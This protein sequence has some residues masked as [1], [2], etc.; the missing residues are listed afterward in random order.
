MEKLLR[1]YLNTIY[2]KTR[3]G[4]QTEGSYYGA[5]ED[6]FTDYP[7]EKGRK[8]KVT[9]LPKKTEAGN[10]DFRVWDGD[11]FIVGYIEAKTPGTNLDQVETSE[12][13]QRYIHTF[14]N[15][16]LTDFYEFRLYRDG[17]HIDSATIARYH[18]AKAL[19]T[20]PTLQNID[21]FERLANAFFS[22]KLPKSF[23]A[24]SLATQLAKRTRFLRDIVF[25]QLEEEIPI[26]KGDL[27]NYY[28]AFKRYL[29]TSLTPQSFAD[30]YA[31][32]ITY[33]MFA[34]RTRNQH[35]FTRK[36]AVEYV[37]HTTGILS[38][39]FEY[40]SYAKS[41]EQITVTIDDIAAVLN[42]ADINSILDQYYKQGKG[43]DPIMHFYETFLNQY[44]PSMREKRGV[45]YT[46]ESV[47][48]Y[49]V[50]SVHEILKTDFNMPDGLANKDVTL[51]D[52]AAGTLT[53][54]AEAIKLAVETYVNKYGEGGKDN[55]IRRQILPNFFAFELMMAPYAIGHMKVAYLLES[56]GFQM[57]GDDAFKLYLTNTLE[58]DEIE[59][60]PL[61]FVASLSE[62]S[63]KAGEVKREPVLVIL[64]NPPYSGTSANVNDW[65]EE[66]L[67]T[68]I[69]GAQSYYKV[70]GNPLGERN[71]KMLQDDYVKFLRFA[72]WKIQKAGKG[73][74]AMI[75]N[76]AWLENPTFRG[77]RQSMMNTF[78]KIYIL[79]LHGNSLKKETA[80][81]GSK[82]ENVFDIRVGVAI[83]LLV[84]TPNSEKADRTVQHSDLYGSRETKYELLNVNDLTSTNWKQL[85]PGSGFYL[86]SPRDETKY[87]EYK[88]FV[89]VTDIFP[90]NSTGIKTHRDAFVIDSDKNALERRISQFRDL[91]LSDEI[92]RKAFNL[93][94]TRDWSMS[95]A[96]KQLAENQNWKNH[97]SSITY[98]PFDN[99]FIYNSSEL[100]EWPRKE[101]MQHMSEENLMLITVRQVAE[102][103]FSHAFISDILVES[104]ITTSNRGMAYVFPLYLY[105]DEENHEG[106]L[107]MEGIDG[108]VLEKTANIDQM[109]MKKLED[110][111]GK[112]VSPE[113]VL[114]YIY[115]VLYSPSYRSVYA[116]FLKFDYPRIPFTSDYALFR[117]MAE[118]G[119]RLKDLHLMTSDEINEPVVR[120]QGQGEDIVK[121]RRYNEDEKRLYINE[122]KYFEHLEPEVWEYQ[123]GGYQVLDKYLKDR[124]KQKLESPR[125]V[126][127]IATALSKTIE[128]QAEIDELYPEVERELVEF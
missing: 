44:D 119:E 106:L 38:D 17:V 35:E 94:D 23:T 82:D 47:V 21:D 125:H 123:I 54:P 60:Q 53:F 98:R 84:K 45:Y 65:T 113:D 110:N 27:Y 28:Q 124:S 81:D 16:I 29:I 101:T 8:T 50:R 57:K 69:D 83:S 40:I 73:I 72:Q 46:P 51:L 128:I 52:P 19:K 86:L 43:E 74:V 61:P 55:F 120:Y 18:T 34:A 58:M 32:T 79:D 104:R 89:Q 99:Q 90:V 26:E 62:E 7:L 5:V 71:P 87:S 100:V 127:R 48:K 1:Q 6:L 96:R 107:P 56:L 103:V 42:V 77:M 2:E 78:D 13:L 102:G 80:P 22:F 111:Y 117:Q 30:L 70:D 10:P 66:L 33:G 115:A 11:N 88:S 25:N 59:K 64:G 68:D 9:I 37:P 114:F 24:E 85:Q 39:L 92:I 118:L 95:K 97:I 20:K 3:S 76:H 41:E 93:K 105:P 4:D 122:N 121:F 109:L 116:D 15:V 67:K 112:N 49:I 31:Q 14:P 63:H 108:V 75:T 36:N 12:Q 126:I 91:S